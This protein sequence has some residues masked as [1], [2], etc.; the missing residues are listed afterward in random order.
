ML[1]CSFCSFTQAALE[2]AGREKWPPL[3]S[4]PIYLYTIINDILHTAET[5]ITKN[6]GI[7]TEYILIL[8]HREE[9]ISSDLVYI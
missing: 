2:P 4:V 9:I 8:R 3:F 6:E 1:T 5:D 7:P